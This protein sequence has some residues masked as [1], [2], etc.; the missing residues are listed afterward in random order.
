MLNF[1]FPKNS[2]GRRLICISG[3]ILI[4]LKSQEQVFT[5]D[6]L[7]RN[8]ER[9]NRINFVYISD[10][11]QSAELNTFITNANTINN[12]MFSQTPFADYKNYFNTYAI[13]VP[14]N[15]SGAKHPGTAADEASV[16][17]AQPVANPDNYFQSTFDYASI[18]RLLVPQ[19]NTD[20]YNVL[21]SNLPDYD[22]PFAVVNSSYYGGSGGAVAT[23]SADPSS[24]EVAIHE[25]G[26][27]F[28]GLADE[29]WA[30]PTYAAERPN[31]TQD[32][33]PA[34]I[35]WKNWLGINS[36]G[37]YPHAED[38]TWFRPHESCKMRF[39]GY[40]FCS[41]CTERLI[42]RIH[43]L[44]NMIDSITPTATSFTLSNT[45]DVDFSVTTVQTIPS[46]IGVNWYLNASTTPFATNQ[47]NVTVPFASLL[48]GNNTVRAEVLDSTTLSKSYLAAAGYINSITWTVNKPSSLPVHLK[49]FSGVVKQFTGSLRWE[50]DNSAELQ[51]FELERSND[52]KNFSTIA[53]ING[54]LNKGSYNYE[55]PDLLIPFTYYR[56]KITE[57]GGK[58]FYSNILRLQNAFD[59]LTYKIYQDADNHKYHLKI[60]L[61]KSEKIAIKI[62][63][64]NGRQILHKEFGIIQNGLDHNIELTNKP[65]GLYLLTIYISQKN[66]TV[67]LVA[68]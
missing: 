65:A 29:Y 31:M 39:L 4:A 48:D 11:Y 16:V 66:Y 63:D 8:G 1:N 35:K 49:N 62:N 52:G 64:V 38:P 47:E 53:V 54:E 24:A 22:Q 25:I 19:N 68:N 7:F 17:P 27:S 5:V 57:I 14:S 55:D 46:T 23:A 18:H 6:T 33:N 60:G 2:I 43:E 32:N 13:R 42:D 34:T 56:L 44:V 36:I 12:S 9:T 3:I 51:K 45:N 15:Q 26:H 10:G 61:A 20:I 59:K 21:A 40:A 37:I 28:A 50:V 30:G 58:V 67:W 41:V